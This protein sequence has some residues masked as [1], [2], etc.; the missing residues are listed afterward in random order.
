MDLHDVSNVERHFQDLALRKTHLRAASRRKGQ[1]PTDRL[2]RD[3]IINQQMQSVQLSRIEQMALGPPKTDM[4][5]SFL[6]PSYLPSIKS[7][8]DLKQTFIKDLKLETHH[9][10]SYILLKAVTPPRRMAGIL[11][12]VEDE[13][14][15]VVWMQI[16]QQEHEEVRSARE[17]ISP[18]SVIIVKEPYFKITSDC[19]ALRADHVSDLIW[20]TE[21]DD[22][23]PECWRPRIMEIGQTAIDWKQGGDADLNAEKL[24][25]AVRKYIVPPSRKFALLKLV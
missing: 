11:T 21:D 23:V 24:H 20:L 8:K 4:Y 12:V 15:E 17:I 5:T 9:R 6:P 22:L 10:G 16:Y 7:L 18:D 19:Y 3:E 2:S 25:D 14:D 1:V 13:K